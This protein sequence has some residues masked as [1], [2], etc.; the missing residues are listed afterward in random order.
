MQTNLKELVGKYKKELPTQGTIPNTEF[1]IKLMSNKIVQTTEYPVPIELGPKILTL[2]ND[3]VQNTTIQSSTSRFSSPAF[4]V[5][6]P[7]DDIRLVVEYKALNAITETQTYPFPAIQD[8]FIDLKG[9]TVF[10]KLDLTAGYYQIKIKESDIQ[11]TA[12]VIMG[13]KYEF[14]RLLFGLK[15]APYF[16]REPCTIS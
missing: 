6:K 15:N 8:Q 2:L 1:E 11:K 9:A 4:P 16:F 14:L 13:R 3:I 7:N 10:S 5:P 12:F